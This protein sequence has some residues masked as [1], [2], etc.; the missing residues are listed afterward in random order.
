MDQKAS[1]E[2]VTDSASLAGLETS[3]ASW[4]TSRWF[5][6]LLLLIPLAVFIL[7]LIRRRLRKVARERVFNQ[8]Y[9]RNSFDSDMEKGL[10]SRN[11]NPFS[12][13]TWFPP[14]KDNPP[15]NMSGSTLESSLY[16]DYYKNYPQPHYKE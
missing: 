15:P 11:S 6:L 12:G 10:H 3:F 9:Y 14:L 8:H 2:G 1:A 5:L 16:S 7:V 13:D 4:N